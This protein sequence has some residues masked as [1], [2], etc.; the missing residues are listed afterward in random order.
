MTN[1]DNNPLAAVQSAIIERLKRGGRFSTSHKEGGSHFLWQSGRFLRSDYG[2]FPGERSFTDD[3]EFLNALWRTC[4]HDVTRAAD[5]SKLTE[6]EGWQRILQ[7]IENGTSSASAVRYMSSIKGG[8]ALVLLLLIGA[9]MAAWQFVSLPSTGTP[10]G[11]AFIS[12]THVLQLIVTTERHLPQLHRVP[13]KDRYRIDLLAVSLSDPKRQDTFT[14]LR[15]QQTNALTPITQILGVD[16]DVAWVQALEIFAVNLRTGRVSREVDLRKAN[17][18]LELFLASAKPSFDARFVAVS[19]DWSLAYGFNSETLKASACLPPDRSGWVNE[20]TK[21]RLEHSLCSGGWTE[22]GGWLGLAT[23]ED[24]KANFNPGTS[25]PRDFT[26]ND[27]DQQRFLYGGTITNAA[28]RPEYE[29][30]RQLSEIPYRAA[31]FLRAEPRGPLLLAADPLSAFMLHRE[32]AELFA[33]FSLRRVDV[34]GNPIWNSP[35][36]IARISQVLPG[37]RVLALVGERTPVPEKVPEPVLVLV[38]AETGSIDTVSL[39]R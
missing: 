26:V 4:Q 6:L 24:A 7:R 27:K 21:G 25:M 14:L 13:G 37:E 9:G 1:E 23:S 38:N 19:P 5:G 22:A 36:G 17:P 10:L 18:E 3:R 31:S 39:W 12:P 15:Q 11:L 33:P 30:V 29:S 2:D 35:T 8:L 20:H 34:Q 16:G 32:G 28:P